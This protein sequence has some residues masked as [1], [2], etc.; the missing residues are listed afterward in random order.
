MGVGRKLTDVWYH[1][2]VV[3]Y[4]MREV[5]EQLKPNLPTVVD[6]SVAPASHSGGSGFKSRPRVWLS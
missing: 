1:K 3:P 6:G 5:A 2:S 4:K